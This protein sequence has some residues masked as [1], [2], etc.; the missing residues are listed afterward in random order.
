MIAGQNTA[1]RTSVRDRISL[2]LDTWAVTLALCLALLV[3]LG[4]LKQIPW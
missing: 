3:G 1:Q 2:S 4:V